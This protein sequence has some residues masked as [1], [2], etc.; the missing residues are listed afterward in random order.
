MT[1]LRPVIVVRSSVQNPAIPCDQR[2]VQGLS[3]ASPVRAPSGRNRF[4]CRRTKTVGLRPTV[5][6]RCLMAGVAGRRPAGT[7]ASGLLLQAF[8]SAR[9]IQGP[10][11]HAPNRGRNR[12]DHRTITGRSWGNFG[13]LEASIRL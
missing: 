13:T 11:H 2:L 9:T 12:V 1:A 10:N 8:N 5:L 4:H 3:T 6:V 7:A